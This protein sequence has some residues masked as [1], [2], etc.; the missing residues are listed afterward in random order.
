[1]FYSKIIQIEIF[2]EIQVRP[3]C[4]SN[5]GKLV[6]FWCWFSCSEANRP[7]TEM[8]NPRLCLRWC[9]S[10]TIHINC[11]CDVWC[12]YACF[13]PWN[14]GFF[15]AHLA[16]SLAHGKR[17]LFHPLISRIWPSPWSENPWAMET[18]SQTCPILSSMLTSVATANFHL[19]TWHCI[20]LDK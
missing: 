18:H 2:L 16:T 9:L 7:Y 11:I 13:D 3:T 4:I 15:R 12:Q 5:L 19:L 6:W 1:M 10:C 14:S 20:S 17:Q 8:G